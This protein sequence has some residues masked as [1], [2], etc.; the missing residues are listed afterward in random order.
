MNI[1]KPP[2]RLDQAE[3]LVVDKTI[4]ENLVRLLHAARNVFHGVESSEIDVSRVQL[5]YD[6]VI[7]LD[8]YE[9]QWL[10]VALQ[11]E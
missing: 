6:A 1:L 4:F 11:H 10:H 9:D 5:L 7:D 3:M 8:E 2:G